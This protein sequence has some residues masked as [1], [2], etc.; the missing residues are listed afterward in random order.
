ME[1]VR[2]SKSTVKH[3]TE[4]IRQ[5]LTFM[6]AGKEYGIDVLRVEGIIEWS[7]TTS[8][9]ISHHYI[10]GTVTLMG[11]LVAI[12]DLR[13]RLGLPGYHPRTA[14]VVVVLLVDATSTERRV[15]LIVDALSWIV[16]TSCDPNGV[17]ASLMPGVRHLRAGVC[18]FKSRP[19][20]VLDPDR[21]FDVSSSS[22]AMAA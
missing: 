11:E 2:P 17:N 21:I 1:Y 20:I 7:A 12:A 10:K 4:H 9:S 13:E 14:L 5:L 3:D 16:P 8:L 22:R 15:G 6:L 19:I 18:R